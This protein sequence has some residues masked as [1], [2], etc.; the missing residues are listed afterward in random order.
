MDATY[1]NL[2]DTQVLLATG[3]V[4][5]NGG[6]SFYLRLGMERMLL[7]AAVR[8]VLQLLLIGFVLQWVFAGNQWYLSLLLIVTMTTVA[9]ITASDRVKFHYPGM[10][11]HGML[12]IWL[13]A[14]LVTGFAVFG[15]MRLQP[16]YLPQYLVPLLGMILGNSLNGICLALDRMGSEVTFRKTEL[17]SQLALGANR[18]EAAH[19]HIVAAI[20]TGMV[21]MLNTMS[22]VGLV[23]LPGMMTGQL[24]AGV[25]PLNAVKYQIVV[26]FLIAATTMFGTVG[27]ALLAYRQMFN[28]SHQ[29]IAPLPATKK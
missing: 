11:L 19:P 7:V 1:I 16:W 10:R 26:M 4:V 12:A 3:L 20:R 17:E 21:P 18:W 25:D 9:G 14:W 22:V 2:S 24:L 13:S 5:I 23:S 27:V 6:L 15:I 28:A 8:T 29:F